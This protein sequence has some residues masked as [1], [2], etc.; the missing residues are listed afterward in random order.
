M[1]KDRRSAEWFGIE[2]QPASESNRGQDC[3]NLPSPQADG[4]AVRSPGSPWR[5]SDAEQTMNRL[6]NTPAHERSNPGTW[7]AATHHANLSDTRSSCYSTQSVSVPG[8]CES[9]PTCH[10]YADHD[11]RQRQHAFRMRSIGAHSET[12]RDTNSACEQDEHGAAGCR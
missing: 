4:T 10:A 8:P 7:R 9:E 6:L 2:L 1:K 12:R 3:S 5:V 11:P